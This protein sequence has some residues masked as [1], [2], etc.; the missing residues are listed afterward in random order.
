[1]QHLLSYYICRVRVAA[2]TENDITLLKSRV[3]HDGDDTYPQDALH[4][5]RKNID[6]AEHNMTRL[7]KLAPKTDHRA[8]DDIYEGTNQTNFCITYP[9]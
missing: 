7:N 1:M 4:V 9:K 6:V 5:Y 3:V 8:D 2:C